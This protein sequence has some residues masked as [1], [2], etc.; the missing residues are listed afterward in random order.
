MTQRPCPA[1]LPLPHPISTSCHSTFGGQNN[2]LCGRF[3][4]SLWF[5]CPAK[6]LEWLALCSCPSSRQP[7]NQKTD[8]KE[9]RV[10]R[11][12]SYQSSAS[13]E[14]DTASV[15]GGLWGDTV[16]KAV[17]VL[18]TKNIPEDVPAKKAQPLP[19]VFKLEG[20]DLSAE[21]EEN[22]YGL[23]MMGFFRHM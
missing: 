19:R 10:K 8:S 23:K 5:S 2:H 20:L 21:G 4:C 22:F 3:S 11:E 15:S 16:V 17:Q 1:V 7:E 18:G 6:E 14:A 12:H 13:L 9:I